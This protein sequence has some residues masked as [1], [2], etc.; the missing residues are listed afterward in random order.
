M[1]KIL[2]LLLN[3]FKSKTPRAF[4]AL[5][6]GAGVVGLGVLAVPLL[7]ITLPAFVV[8]A[9]PLIEL[10]CGAIITVSLNKTE[11]ENLIKET[12]K[13]VDKAF[14]IKRK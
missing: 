14:K 9:V 8:S 1:K 7:P 2:V 6:I 4:K 13:V 3:R 5:A 12:K 11:N 10:I